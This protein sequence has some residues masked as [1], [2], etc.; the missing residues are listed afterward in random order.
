MLSKYHLHCYFC[1]RNITY[2][3]IYCITP[4]FASGD[5]NF[6][7]LVIDDERVIWDRFKYTE[8]P[9]YDSVQPQSTI[10]A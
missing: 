7:V 3:E 10:P 5:N 4:A 2:S 9:Q 8:D 1:G 6:V